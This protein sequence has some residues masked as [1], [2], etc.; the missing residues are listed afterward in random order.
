MDGAPVTAA[1]TKRGLR[2][3]LTGAVIDRWWP[4]R[5][6]VVVRRLKTRLHV[7]WLD[8][9]I[10]SYDTAHTQFLK[11]YRIKRVHA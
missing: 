9:E 7:R 5:V 11:L 8:G 10:W 6:G 3:D 1:V 2:P 4:H